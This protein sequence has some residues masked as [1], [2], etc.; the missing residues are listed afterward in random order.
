MMMMMMGRD[1]RDFRG[2]VVLGGS[3]SGSGG[4]GG[5]RGWLGGR[6]RGT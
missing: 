2:G 4:G 6:E 1:C 3:G 5:W